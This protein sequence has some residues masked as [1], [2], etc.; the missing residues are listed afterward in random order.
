MTEQTNRCKGGWLLYWEFCDSY[1]IA[2]E[3]TTW[4]DYDEALIA[5]RNHHHECEQC[6][7]RTV[8]LVEQGKIMEWPTTKAPEY[9]G[10]GGD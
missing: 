6:H 1:K 10:A 3:Q 2:T 4:Q 9:A 5:Y 7:G 8:E